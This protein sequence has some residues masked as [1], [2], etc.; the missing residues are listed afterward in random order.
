MLI[1]QSFICHCLLRDFFFKRKNLGRSDGAKQRKNGM[2][3]GAESRSILKGLLGA[4]SVEE[5]NVQKL[6]DSGNPC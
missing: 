1:N 3:L 2:A 5:W 6:S 4:S